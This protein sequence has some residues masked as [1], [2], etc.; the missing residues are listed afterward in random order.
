MKLLLLCLFLGVCSA[1]EIM[2]EDGSARFGF[3]TVGADGDVTIAFNQTSITNLLLI[4]G[5]ALI[6]YL[7]ILPLLD[8]AEESGG[9]YGY[10]QEASY[11]AP[12]GGYEAPAYSY[13]AR[14][15]KEQ[16]PQIMQMLTAAYDK[17]VNK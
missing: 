3:V 6:F 11:S 1:E 7:V 8:P 13:T 4:G 9:G 14:M 10:G 12:A 17:Y 5:A 2:Q 16:G 15:L